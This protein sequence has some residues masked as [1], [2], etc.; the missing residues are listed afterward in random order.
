[1]IWD[2]HGNST[3]LLFEISTD[4][5]IDDEKLLNLD[6]TDFTFR[7]TN[8][9]DNKCFCIHQSD[10]LNI[11]YLKDYL[12]RI[13]GFIDMVFQDLRLIINGEVAVS[14]YNYP[15]IGRVLDFFYD[16]TLYR[17]EGRAAFRILEGIVIG[18]FNIENEGI[19]SIFDSYEQIT[20]TIE[21][22]WKNV[23]K[24]GVDEI[25]I[26]FFKLTIDVVGRMLKKYDEEVKWVLKTNLFTFVIDHVLE[27]KSN[28]ILNQ[29][30]Q[31]EEEKLKA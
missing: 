9:I 19:A 16:H 12:E 29:L 3:N 7:N 18:M 24:Q 11:N 4:E 17:I 1:M 5:K 26:E 6:F 20:N 8:A 22:D 27:G 31:E 10:R 23:W 28:Q 30:R 14:D 25:E 13:A 2:N 15:S 21:K